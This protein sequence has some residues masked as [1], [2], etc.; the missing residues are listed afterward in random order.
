MLVLGGLAGFVVPEGSAGGGDVARGW[1]KPTLGDVDPCS[2]GAVATGFAFLPMAGRHLRDDRRGQEFTEPPAV[3]MIA[4]VGA[5]R[6]PRCRGRLPGDPEAAR[7]ATRGRCV[8]A[9]WALSVVASTRLP[10]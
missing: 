10:R 7:A 4:G 8:I 2:P 6:G 5:A 9:V 1:P 3:P